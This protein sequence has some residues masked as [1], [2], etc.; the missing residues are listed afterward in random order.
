MV[1][2]SPRT[3][4]CRR[5]SSRKAGA[6]DRRLVLLL[7]LLAASGVAVIALLR[8][9]SDPSGS[10]HHAAPSSVAA[11]VANV[12]RPPT[13]TRP[14]TDR[15]AAAAKDSMRPATV[16]LPVED[17]NG[18]VLTSVVA[19]SY[20]RFSEPSGLRIEVVANRGIVALTA[21]R[22]CPDLDLLLLSAPGIAPRT[23]RELPFPGGDTTIDRLRF[24][25]G[26]TLRGRVVGPANEPLAKRA[27]T[28]FDANSTPLDRATGRTLPLATATSDAQG[29]FIFRHVHAR[30]VRCEI[31]GGDGLAG[32]V[33]A[34]AIAGE[35]PVELAVRGVE[36]PLTGVVVDGAGKP[37]A[38]AVV[39]ATMAGPIERCCQRATC[40]AE[41]RFKL[42]RL[43]RGYYVLEASA[44]GFVPRL[45]PR[46]H[47][48]TAGI[49]LVLDAAAIAELELVGA[50]RD[51]DLPLLW[52][53]LDGSG[54]RRRATGAF[55]F[56]RWRDGKA[57]LTGVPPGRHAFEIRVPGAAPFQTTA[58]VFEAGRTTLLGTWE[59]AAGTSIVAH[60]TGPDGRAIGG[61][62]ALAAAF[63]EALMVDREVF[64]L[65]G[66]EERVVDDDGTL[67]WNDLPAGPRTL[68]LRA[69]G[70]ADRNL[71]IELP[72]SGTL[73]L[74]TIALEAAG[75][76]EGVVRRLSGVPLGDATV[77]AERVGGAQFEVVTA[78][79]G[80]YQFARL[81]AGRYDVRLLPA[82]DP[83]HLVL[84]VPTPDAELTVGGGLAG[85][86]DGD[87]IR[88]DVV[89]GAVTRGEIQLDQ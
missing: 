32:T 41:G 81:P 38:G 37:V 14:L 46:A 59:L 1:M 62:A 16:T 54:A 28:L 12:S 7:L 61:R 51:L 58:L 66:H 65:A 80:T 10:T 13:D 50:P 40:D 70:C 47:S 53:T 72:A 17:P 55:Q 64:A 26:A 3:R 60:V 79:D 69:S 84:D 75:S 35:T 19:L 34:E 86:S 2:P 87:M 74:A 73:D 21:P 63:Q 49:P 27:V 82:D 56:C 39:A 43:A 85:D 30:V 20:S 71:A 33:L 11:P 18:E 36:P 67:R 31:E 25:P 89:A 48:G 5:D 23:F 24:A 78:A 57:L 76:L 44:R 9:D 77:M 88:I 52:R 42:D 15:I 6:I 83:M 4:N 29:G 22:L 8:K 68:A 45:V